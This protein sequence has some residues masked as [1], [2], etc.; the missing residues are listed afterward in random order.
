MLI[1]WYL[2]LLCFPENLYLKIVEDEEKATTLAV[3]I[4]IS[5][6]TGHK[7]AIHTAAVQFMG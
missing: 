2:V 5:R 4:S 3:Q 6:S 1:G 7:S